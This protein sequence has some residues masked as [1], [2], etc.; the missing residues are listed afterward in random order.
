[1]MSYE[2]IFFPGNGVWFCSCLVYWFHHVRPSVDK[3]YVL[4]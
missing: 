2:Y 1:V 4:R 3:S